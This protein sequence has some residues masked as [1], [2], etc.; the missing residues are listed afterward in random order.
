VHLDIDYMDGHRVFTVDPKRFPDLAAL[1][2]ECDGKGV[3]LVA[4]LDPGVKEDE[5]LPLYRE[6]V[7][8]GLFC[9][10][11]GGRK[12]RGPVWPGACAFP[13]F[14]KPATRAWWAAQY[15][16][17]LE[18]GITGAWHDMNEPSV[19]GAWGEATLPLST[20]HDLDG[21][22]GDHREAHNLYALLEAR[23][24]FEGMSAHRPGQRPWILSRSGWVGLQRY[25]WNWTGD[26]ESST[27]SLRQSVRIALSMGLSGIP[28]TGPDVG[29]FGG[30]PSAALFTR[31][32][33]CAAFLPFFRTHSAFFTPR[34]EPWSFDDATLAVARDFLH[35]RYRL[36]PY[37]YTLA[38]QASRT[39]APLVRPMWWDRPGD[40]MLLGVDDQFL[41]GDAFLVAPILDEAGG[42]RDLVLP[43]GRW[44]SL[45]QE[46]VF[47][48]GP[49]IGKVE[50]VPGKIPVLVRAGSV[51]P[52]DEGGRFVLHAWPP[53]GGEGGGLLYDDAGD[54]AGPS[55]V[56]RFR[57]AFQGSALVLTR[58][59]EGAHP[60]R[61]GSF[62]VQLRGARAG[63]VTV[64]GR[65]VPVERERFQAGD[66]REVRIE[67]LG[68][69]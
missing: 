42:L 69:L 23:A 55:R 31:W 33:Q 60:L 45:W 22:G 34:R 3:K 20:R 62:D 29:G 28:Y 10:L 52:M 21:R 27:A 11:P 18:Q 2:R 37:W 8:K 39:G 25:A 17:L 61:A 47:V 24:G 54:G 26:S 9:E 66:F 16:R 4:I 50:P 36:M 7:E 46:G 1:G 30:A 67:G 40:A 19:F 63:R 5:S 68:K 48:E 14:T 51:V 58:T 13:D 64:D 53:A 57:L 56:E 49:A 15:P 44:Y 43:P 65:E 38:W 35:L 12:L 41:A 6:G 32:F 59:S